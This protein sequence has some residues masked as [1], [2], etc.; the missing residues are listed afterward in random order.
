MN[1]S[2]RRIVIVGGGIGGLATAFYLR[3]AAAERKYLLDITLLEAS[4]RLGGVIETQAREGF[5]LEL[6]PDCFISDKPAGLAL[7]EALG[8]EK[9]MIGTHPAHRRS[10]VLRGR[11]LLTVPEG[12]YLMAP[13]SIWPFLRSRIL[14]WPGKLRAG[15]DVVIPRKILDD[16]SLGSFVRRRLGQEVLERIAQPMIGGIYGA[17]PDALSLRATMPR[18]LELEKE[19]GSIIRGLRVKRASTSPTGTSGPRY[20][21]FV[22][23]Q[24]GMESMI[25]ALK[26]KLGDSIE[27]DHGVRTIEKTSTGWRMATNRRK[28][29]AD[30]VVLALS[31]IRAK[32]IIR[33]VD[34]AIAALIETIPH[35][36]ISTINFAYRRNQ[37]GH[38]LNG[39]GFVVP[40]TEKRKLIACSFSSQKFPGRAPE[41]SVLLRAFV[42]GT[43]DH[44]NEVERELAEILSIHGDPLFAVV[45]RYDRA[46]PHAP[47]GHVKRVEEMD[48]A[49]SKHLGLHVVGN[50]YA[51]V[52]IPDICARAEQV[53]QSIIDLSFR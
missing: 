8:L 3:R 15:L 33:P 43:E 22:S 31:A 51:G 5:L 14:S 4:S 53:A 9:E 44:T 38:P 19:Y 41:D 25:H 13:T 36:S 46:M 24:N 11:E 47:P 17:N 28:I 34:S 10:F 1:S 26:E 23:F 39:M 6:G 27:R 52:G 45:A 42:H 12:F 32:E 18:F 29:D 48:R 49:L 50:A 21:L 30:V 20:G 35:G 40:A 7:A 2:L 16:E 37:I